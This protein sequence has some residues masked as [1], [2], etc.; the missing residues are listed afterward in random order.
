MQT[1]QTVKKAV[2]PIEQEKFG[3]S[4]DEYDAEV[5]TRLVTKGKIQS[6]KDYMCTFFAKIR[7]PTSHVMVWS[8][9]RGT[10]DVVP[11]AGIKDTYIPSGIKYYEVDESGRSK[12]GFQAQQWF[13][14]NNTKLYDQDINPAK[15][16]HYT[17][18]GI[19]YINQYIGCRF[20]GCQEYDKYDVELKTSV[21]KIFDH[22]KNIWCS[23]NELVFIYVHNW[24]V[25]SVTAHKLETYLY[26]KGGQGIGKSIITE[27]LHK[28]IGVASKVADDPKGIIGDF[29][30][31]LL[32]KILLVLEEAPCATKGSWMGF[33]NRIKNVVTGQTLEINQKYKPRMDIIN[34]I[35]LIINT[36]NNAIKLETYD[37]RAVPLDLD[38]KR[39]GDFA[40]FDA[41]AM[42]LD[43]EKVQECF[44]AYCI[45]CAGPL[46]NWKGRVIPRTN[47]KMDLLNDN[48]SP[49]LRFIKCAFVLQNKG[50]DK[51]LFSE[52]Y[53]DYKA[54]TVENHMNT[55]SNIE[56]SKMLT[57]N[58][59]E[60]MKGTGNKTF[61]RISKEQLRELF[62]K[63]NWIHT[64]DEFNEENVEV[65]LKELDE[66][67]KQLQNK[68]NELKEQIKQPSKPKKEVNNTEKNF[69]EK[70]EVKSTIKE[71]KTKTTNTITTQTEKVKTTEIKVKEV[72][73]TETKKVEP[74]TAQ[75]DPDYERCEGYDECLFNEPEKQEKIILKLNDDSEED[76]I[77]VKGNKKSAE[78][79]ELDEEDELNEE[80]EENLKQVLKWSK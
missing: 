43:D 54:Y 36:N 68:H 79:D 4:T 40:Y 30:G 74:V 9:G 52:F 46:Q 16:L 15:G 45:K 47:A 58:G 35:N 65:E 50:I 22:I 44:Y 10:C 5:L 34:M 80:D 72:K 17:V 56:V 19:K 70:A 14:Q 41:L 64:L 48:L 67:I 11:F 78:E 18:K 69:M 51:M 1:K 55:D 21:N 49:L 26:L 75:R 77:V 38:P 39:V 63:R 3:S 32:G 2:A 73:K 27:F 33:S 76:V 13:L 6:A 57:S 71:V 20:K 61:V 60:V 53:Q 24:I 25:L 59:I 12:I 28:V 42:I 62:D 29:N 37:R 31:Q 66:Q 23:N 8:P 7:N